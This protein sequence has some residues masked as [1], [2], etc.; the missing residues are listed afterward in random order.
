[1]TA[2]YESLKNIKI[3]NAQNLLNQPVP[4]QRL[5]KLDPIPPYRLYPKRNGNGEY[6]LRMKRGRNKYLRSRR[7]AID[8]YMYQGH[9]FQF[10]IF[11]V[12]TF[13]ELKEHLT[14][15]MAN[16]KKEFDSVFIVGHLSLPYERIPGY[17]RS[18]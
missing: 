6:K 2:Y 8:Q 11:Q 4:G 1:M 9:I 5:P 18:E 15:L 16:Y 7:R 10:D 12:E 3:Q 13:T 17:N 14:P